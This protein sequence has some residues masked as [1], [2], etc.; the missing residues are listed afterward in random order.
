MRVQIGL[1]DVHPALAGFALIGIA[2][3]APA[4][5]EAR[6]AVLGPLRM[7]YAR[8]IAAV[9]QASEALLSLPQ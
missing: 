5:I 3:A 7:N 4:G 9:N 8:V 2:V 1:E 6:V